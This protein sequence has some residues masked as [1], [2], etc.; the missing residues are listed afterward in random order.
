MLGTPRCV[1]RSGR[2]VAR[3]PCPLLSLALPSAQARAPA[4]R[5]SRT[6]PPRSPAAAVPPPWPAGPPPAGSDLP[7]SSSPPEAPEPWGREACLARALSH[8]VRFLRTDWVG[9]T[10][11]NR[12]SLSEHAAILGPFF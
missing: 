1:A 5:P 8:R 12:R 6:E 4:E 7:R 11:D 3:L 10:D 2:T 9:G